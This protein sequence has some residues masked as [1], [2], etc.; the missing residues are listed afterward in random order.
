MSEPDPAQE[1][2]RDTTAAEPAI[3]PLGRLRHL[4]KGFVLLLLL[5]GFGM[6]LITRGLLVAITGDD[7]SNLPALIERVEPVPEAIQVLSQSN[8]F[9]DLADG[10]TGVLVIDG[11]E[12]ETVSIEDLGSVGVE[13]G[14]QVQ[15]P[16]VTIYEPGNAT[17][18]FTPGQDAP[19]PEFTEGRHRAQVIY[20]RVVDGRQRA[21]SYSW[22]FQV[23]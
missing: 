19:I 7:R 4:D 18:T 20:W 6:A 9:V 14:Q 15:L 13:P 10:Y 11:V 23:V 21:R 16:P 17:L 2:S 5:V 8:V 1:T 3:G 22:T 12:I